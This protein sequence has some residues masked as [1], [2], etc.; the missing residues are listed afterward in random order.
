MWSATG[1]R[2]TRECRRRCHGKVLAALACP[3]YVQAVCP[4]GKGGY[5]SA[6]EVTG[7]ELSAEGGA[8]QTPHGRSGGWGTLSTTAADKPGSIGC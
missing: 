6:K 1:G 3:G 5:L 8:G 2:G 4:T 7:C